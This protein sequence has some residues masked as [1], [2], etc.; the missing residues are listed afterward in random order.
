MR[1]S[2]LQTMNTSPHFWHLP[3]NLQYVMRQWWSF[4]QPRQ[5][6]QGW[7]LLA[8]G[9]YNTVFAVF[10]TFVFVGFIRSAQ[11]WPTFLE[12]LLISN[13]IGYSIH[14]MFELVMRLFLKNGLSGMKP[15]ARMASITSIMLTGV[16]VGYTTAFGL[17]GKNFLANMVRSPRFAFGLLLIGLVGCF[18]WVLIM[19][20][21]ARRLRAEAM[22]AQSS[23]LE[24][25][26]RAQ[27]SNAELKALQA[28]IEPHF[29]FNTLAN[30]Q[31][32][33]D[34]EPA[35]AK[36]MLEVFIDYLRATLDA[37]RHTHATLADELH[38]LQRYLEVMSVRMGDRLRFRVDVPDDLRGMAFAPLLL[39]PLVENAIKYGLEPKIE[40]GMITIRV[41]RLAGTDGRIRISVIDDGAGLNPSSQARRGPKSGSGTGMQNVRARLANVFGAGATLSIATESMN[42]VTTVE[43]D[44]KN[45][46]SGTGITP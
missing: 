46:S 15:L 32:L 25:S 14:G 19:E 28:Q 13:C 18:V 35:K 30:V 24:A 6:A 27:A 39:Q 8:T 33:V 44:L 21:Q 4:D 22:E 17:V 41:E 20:G 5:G 45:A 2:K 23:A 12:T 34:Y 43:F 40:G 3:T 36:Q 1:M 11:W 37:S 7:F 9:I 29:L 38:L 31:A 16:L 26:L 42:T 10:L